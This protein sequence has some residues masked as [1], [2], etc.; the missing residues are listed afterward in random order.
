[1]EKSMVFLRKSWKILGFSKKIQ[2]KSM[3][4]SLSDH[5]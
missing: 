3:G 5:G 4:K 2:G 1:M